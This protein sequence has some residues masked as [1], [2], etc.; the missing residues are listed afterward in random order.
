MS[1]H[2]QMYVDTSIFKNRQARLS[3]CRIFANHPRIAGARRAVCLHCKQHELQRAGMQ[4]PE[5]PSSAALWY[6][7]W[8][9]VRGRAIVTCISYNFRSQLEG[10]AQRPACRL[11]FLEDITQTLDKI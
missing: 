6:G 9:S 5:N 1:A 7:D 2:T 10:R 8:W 11:S 3:N 4:L